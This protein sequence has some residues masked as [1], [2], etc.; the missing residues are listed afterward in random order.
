MA[1]LCLRILNNVLVEKLNF[2]N[3]DVI[4]EF[5]GVI[6]VY[7]FHGIVGYPN[8]IPQLLHPSIMNLPDITHPIQKRKY[9]RNHKIKTKRQSSKK[10]TTE[11]KN[12]ISLETKAIFK[13][14]SDSDISDTES[15]SITQSE[16]KVRLEAAHLLNTLVEQSQNRELFG[17]WTQIVASGSRTDARVLTR[18]IL[19]E[20]LS[21]IRQIALITLNN[22]LI[23][24]R[25]FLTHAEDIE[26]MSF[27]TFFGMLSSII[28]E[29]HFT[30]SLLLSTERNV[31]VLTQGL[32]CAAA[33]IQGTP[34]SRLKPGLATK[35][36]R[37]CRNH[38]LHKR[39]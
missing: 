10:A 36:I 34:Y 13:Y 1:S 33:L 15:K 3:T 12:N 27:V 18:C 19:R 17:Y 37:N 30:L 2:D 26:Q 31:V 29:I 21:K 23:G 35:L 7:L 39:K 24:A 32:K 8:I 22:L 4:G 11:N 9:F 16:S 20:P 5:L 25:M 38:L 6:Q 28:K 14:S